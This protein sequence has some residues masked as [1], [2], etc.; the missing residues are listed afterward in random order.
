MIFHIKKRGI[1]RTSTKYTP[2]NALLFKS[3]CP[4]LQLHLFNIYLSIS[5]KSSTS[6]DSTDMKSALPKLTQAIN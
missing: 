1:F 4:T 2:L 5:N 3:I 6:V